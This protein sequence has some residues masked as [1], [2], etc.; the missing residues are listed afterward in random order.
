[1]VV[2]KNKVYK[3][4]FKF[5]RNIPNNIKKTKYY[6]YILDIN[7]KYCKCKYCVNIFNIK[8]DKYLESL[9]IGPI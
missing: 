6:K 9:K 1:M 2:L 5:S 3:C 8:E 4:Y 7:R